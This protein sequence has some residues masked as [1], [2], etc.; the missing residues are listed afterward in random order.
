[1]AGCVVFDLDG[2]LVDSAPMIR[3]L[4]NTMLADRGAGPALSLEE[5]RPHVTAGG[6]GT[7]EAL[8]RGRCGATEEALTEFRA[9]YAQANTS[10]SLVYPGALEA[11]R[12]LRGR[13][14][15]LA[16]FSNKIQ[17]LCDKVLADVG[18]AAFFDAIVGTGP[19]VPQKPDVTGYRLAVQRSGGRL[20]VS[21][22][23]GD[24]EADIATAQAAE[25]PL[26][27]AAWGYG[28]APRDV[29]VAQRFEDV[30]GLATRALIDR[31]T[32]QAID[33]EGLTGAGAS[34]L[35]DS[36][37]RVVVVGA[38]GWMGLATLELLHRLLGPDAFSE[39]VIAFGSRRRTLGLRDGL[40]VEQRPLDEL[41]TLSPA[42]TIVLHLAFLT[43]EKAKVMSE[44]DYVSANTAISRRVR[45]ALDPIGS[46]GVFVPSSGAVYM[47]DDPSAQPSMRLYGRLKLEDEA[48]FAEWADQGSGRRAVIARVF[49]LSGPYINKQSS[50]ALACFIADVLAGRPIEIRATR[51]VWRSYVA[52]SELMS[53]A[54][55]VLREG[56]SGSIV[57]DTA[58]DQVLEM[59]QIAEVVREALG[60]EATIARSPLD[61][62]AADRYCGDPSVYPTLRSQ[63]GVQPVEFPAQVT[64]TAAYMSAGSSDTPANHTNP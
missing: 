43:Q 28:H 19:D 45:D 9:R 46:L 16:V 2:T 23:V 26:I 27:F 47:V 11:L 17:P 57:F 7:I 33:E 29:Q 61:S 64:T 20:E 34:W 30:P 5:V 32:S 35:V 21:C 22:L 13:G 24:S 54:L 56:G 31:R 41:R 48:M 4:L 59:G 38:G 10:R 49:N 18:L 51:P 50:Y 6:G 14:L 52:I 53:V 37:V 60:A 25:V 36:G 39:Q 1:M 40:C 58:G 63:A 15:R 44:A 8:L 62:D 55:G 42:P 12:T 3:D